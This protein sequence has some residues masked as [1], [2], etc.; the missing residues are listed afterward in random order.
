MSNMNE[1]KRKIILLHTINAYRSTR[2]MAPLIL[3][4]S[5]RCRWVVICPGHFT[6]KKEPIYPINR[7]LGGPN[8]WSEHFG[9][10]PPGIWTPECPAHSLVSKIPATF[11]QSEWWLKWQIA[12]DTYLSEQSAHTNITIWVAKRWGLVGDCTVTISATKWF[13]SF[14]SL[15][16]THS[17]TVLPF[18]VYSN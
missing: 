9:E 16:A 6:P 17:Q 10:H 14:F 8:S 7:R 4:L 12:S 11:K 18:H 13:K 15:H 2:G 3:N 1:Q 5:T